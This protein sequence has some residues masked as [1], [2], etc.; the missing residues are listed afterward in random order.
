VAERVTIAEAA[1]RLGVSADTIQRRMRRGELVGVKEPTP[2]GFRWLVE[3]PEDTPEGGSTS[4]GT[5][6]PPPHVGDSTTGAEV[7]RLE[8]LVDA[9]RTHL[10]VQRALYERQVHDQAEELAARRREVSELHVLLQTLQRALPVPPQ[11]QSSVGADTPAAPGPTPP[12]PRP[13]WQRWRRG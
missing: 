11:D 1:Q 13:W 5:D 7:R 3:L 10:E 12:Q 4:T 6:A 2:Q 8:D 9:Y